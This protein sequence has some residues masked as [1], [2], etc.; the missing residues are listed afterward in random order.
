MATE[1]CT[2]R[3]IDMSSFIPGTYHSEYVEPVATPETSSDPTHTRRA[4]TDFSYTTLA[5]TENRT[6]LSVTIPG[7]RRRK[8][9]P[10][11]KATA[12]RER[13]LQEAADYSPDIPEHKQIFAA[14][15]VAGESMEGLTQYL[16]G[17][18]D[19]M[20][21]WKYAGA[22]SLTRQL[23]EDCHVSGAGD[24]LRNTGIDRDPRPYHLRPTVIRR[25]WQVDGATAMRIA[26]A[27]KMLS[28]D[29][30]VA[31]HYQAAFKADPIALVELEI[32]AGQLSAVTEIPE[33]DVLSTAARYY[34]DS[35]AD[36]PADDEDPEIETVDYRDADGGFAQF[37]NLD[38]ARDD[39]YHQVAYEG[40]E[41][42]RILNMTSP[43]LPW[44]LK[45]P[46]HIQAIGKALRTATTPDMLKAAC[47]SL[48]EAKVSQIQGK[49]LWG[50]YF[51][52]RDRLH[53]AKYGQPSARAKKF[54]TRLTTPGNA[55]INF[56]AAA[57][58]IRQLG[59]GDRS[60][61]IP[62]LY[63]AQHQQKAQA[64]RA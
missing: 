58:A 25:D 30:S 32:L 60:Y 23:I 11:E 44:S 36:V 12:A 37:V 13:R 61:L 29:V 52:T 18:K 3:C 31:R 15:A 9:T 45:Q 51:R 6:T 33:G 48:I 8:Q 7:G 49:V 14:I 43:A 38:D 47:A 42:V 34:E 63:K 50:I 20:N 56:A 57:A 40:G 21:G 4:R 19:N 59:P 22:S 17:H 1:S 10:E 2:A 41:Q 54:K 5:D 35:N 26:A 24:V 62:A 55:P 16:S 46:V 28:A 39:D 53:I 64:A 27:L